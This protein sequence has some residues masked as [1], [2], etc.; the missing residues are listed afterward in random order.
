MKEICNLNILKQFS[1]LSPEVLNNVIKSRT[2]IKN[3]IDWKDNRIILIIWPCSMDFPNEILEYWK[4]LSEIN[5]KVEDK[6]YIIMRAYSAKPRT[7]VW[8][9]WMLYNWEFWIWWNLIDWITTTRNLMNEIVKLWLPIADEMLYPDL[10][11]YFEDILS[12]V[13]IWARSSENQQHREVASGIEIPVWVKNPTSWELSKLINSVEAIRNPQQA[14]L[15]WVFYET[16]WNKY[17]HAILRWWNIEWENIPNYYKFIELTDIANKRW[18]N[19]KI[20]IDLN[21][22]N[23]WKNPF[24]QIEIMKNVLKDRNSN[25]LWF[26]VESYINDW[27]QK[28]DEN[29][30]NS[31]VKWASIT[32]PCIWLEKTKQ[33]IKELYNNI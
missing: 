8:W 10:L 30:L 27:N 16:L 5:K 2:K 15:L 17:A 26:M 6:I 28:A 24:K 23:S 21:H 9:K 4:L 20:L 29:N 13:A 19:T 7:T 3:I 33:L 31:I 12:Y 14:L 1:K 11:P 18:I 25:L 22:D 32:D